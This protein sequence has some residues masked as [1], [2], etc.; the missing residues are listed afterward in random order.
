MSHIR[1]FKKKG[2]T[3][4]NTVTS[5]RVRI[6]MGTMFAVLGLLLFRLG[7]LQFVQG[8]DLNH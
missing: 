1:T 8:A 3:P 7:F 2:K 5:K 4:A 6:C